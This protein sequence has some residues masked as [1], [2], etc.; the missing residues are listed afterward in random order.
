M[1]LSILYRGPLSSCNYGCDY[2]P[3]AKREESYAEL[4][5]D[6]EALRRFLDWARR[7]HEHRLGLLFTPWGEALIRHWYQDALSELTQMA[8]VR[9]AAIQTNL[10]CSLQWIDHCDTQ[11]LALWC[12]YHPSEVSRADFVSRCQ[13][14]LRRGVRFSVGIVGLK[15]NLN[16]AKALRAELPSAVYVWVNAFKR[17]EHYYTEEEFAQFE[18][19]DPLFAI[20]AKNHPSLGKSCRAG[21]SVVSVDGMGTIRR[22]HFIKDVIGNIHDENWESCL[23]ERTCSNATCGCHIGYVHL[24]ALRLYETYGSGVLERIPE[25]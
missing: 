23:R 19:I 5:L 7:Q 20:N 12:T 21:A 1:D 4:D 24:D 15:E 6:R 9:R 18:S 3:F 11:T 16:E 14:L 10:S 13:E 22:C 25:P 8:H 17:T 2:C